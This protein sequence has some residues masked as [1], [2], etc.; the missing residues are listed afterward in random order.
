MVGKESALGEFPLGQ[1]I[2]RHCILL[3][4]VQ[5]GDRVQRCRSE[6]HLEVKQ[7]PI[8]QRRILCAE[9]WGELHEIDRDI[10]QCEQQWA[11]SKNSLRSNAEFLTKWLNL[12]TSREGYVPYHPNSAAK[13]MLRKLLNQHA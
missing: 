2:Y 1:G 10:K 13:N 3:L 12:L 8:D 11:E 9:C 4:A 6:V 5:E 7:S